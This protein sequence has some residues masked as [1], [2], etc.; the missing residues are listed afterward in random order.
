MSCIKTN[1]TPETI[2]DHL[3]ANIPHP[4]IKQIHSLN[5][6]KWLSVVNMS[7]FP[8]QENLTLSTAVLTLC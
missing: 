2:V 1:F 6:K 7:S 4:Q 5:V 3:Y 8:K